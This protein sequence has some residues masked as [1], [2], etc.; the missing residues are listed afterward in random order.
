[1]SPGLH[2]VEYKLGKQFFSNMESQ[3]VRDADINVKLTVDHKGDFYNLTFDIAGEVTLLCDRC[4]DDLIYPIEAQYKLAVQY[5]SDYN[6]DNDELLIIPESDNTL[7]VSYM[8]YDTVELQIPMKH[9][10]PMGKCNRAISAILKKHRART[11]DDEDSELE[12]QLIEEMD[13]DMSIDDGGAT[14]PRWDALKKLTDNE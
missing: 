7:N 14:D 5:G 1:M 4:L 8:I 12:D 10:H 2:E 9:V 3:D 13:K 6:D 11:A